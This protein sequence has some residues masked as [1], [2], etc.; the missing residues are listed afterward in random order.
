MDQ[1]SARKPSSAPRV[2]SREA[3]ASEPSSGPSVASFDA[4]ARDPSSAPRVASFDPKAR[5][6]CSAPL[7]G[8]R[9]IA[10]KASARRR[11]SPE[12]PVRFEREDEASLCLELFAGVVPVIEDP[13]ISSTGLALGRMHDAAKKSMGY[14]FLDSFGVTLYGQ[15]RVRRFAHRNWPHVCD[16]VECHQHGATTMNNIFYIIGVVVVVLAILGFL[17]LR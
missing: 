2:A 1:P 14:V 13:N 6:R 3:N 5:E 9:A 4:R 15:A 8:P 10:V 16:V 12:S 17:G 11:Q 7:V